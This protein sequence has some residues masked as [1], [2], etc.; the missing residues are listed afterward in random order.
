ML[1]PL[2]RTRLISLHFNWPN[3]HGLAIPTCIESERN[4]V[5][6]GFGMYRLP[7]I[8][9][10]STQSP[11]QSKQK[12]YADVCISSIQGVS[13]YATAM[14]KETSTLNKTDHESGLRFLDMPFGLCS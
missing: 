1:P 10:I 7:T 3:F 8:R 2:T 9:S 12:T 11:T 6:T 13:T 5:L 4:N 14:T